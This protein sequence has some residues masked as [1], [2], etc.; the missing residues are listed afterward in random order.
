MGLYAPLEAS[1]PMTRARVLLSIFPTAKYPYAAFSASATNPLAGLAS[2]DLLYA[3]IG[4]KFDAVDAEFAT[5]HGFEF[6]PRIEGQ[7][8]EGTVLESQVD[9]GLDPRPQ[10]S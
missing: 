6:R 2:I 9:E 7:V 10:T 4:A 1:N 5:D 8:S 3:E